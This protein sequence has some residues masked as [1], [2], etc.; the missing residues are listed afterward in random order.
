MTH[1]VTHGQRLLHK[2]GTLGDQIGVM[3]LA[4]ASGLGIFAASNA[5]PGVANQLLEPLLTHLFG[6]ETRA[7]PPTPMSVPSDNANRAAGTYRDFHRTRNDMSRP[8]SLMLQS[9]VSAEPDGAIRWRD[10]RWVEVAPLVFTSADG[11]DTI[12]FREDA[13]GKI[14]TLHTWGGT[15]EHLGGPSKLSF[16]PPFCSVHGRFRGLPVVPRL[17]A[18]SATSDLD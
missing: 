15:Y 16:T 1:W 3:V 12:V 14:A 11:R 9:R 8:I 5:L 17:R 18:T 13:S 7:V 10:R 2:D 4:P 6:P